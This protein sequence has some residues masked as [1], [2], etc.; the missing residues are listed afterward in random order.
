MFLKSKIYLIVMLAIFFISMKKVS[1]QETVFN[2]N[3]VYASVGSA[4]LYF[5]ATVYYERMIKQKM[6]NKNISSFVKVGYGTEAH[7]GGEST[8]IFGQYG[9]L[10]G[11]KKHHLEISA[12]P[13]FFMSGDDSDIPVAATVGWRIQKPGGNFIFRM[14]VAIPEAAYISVGFTF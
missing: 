3:A 6:W 7:Y 2:K 14:G 5:S 13:N 8:Y 1:A 12:G 9:I 11:I 10:T 4:G